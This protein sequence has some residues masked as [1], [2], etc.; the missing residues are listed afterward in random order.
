MRQSSNFELEVIRHGSSS[1]Q[2]Y[3][4]GK[5]YVEGKQGEEFS[6][7]IKNNTSRRVLAVLTVD[8]LSAMDGKTGSFDSSGYILDPWNGITI[9]GWRLNN[10]EVAHFE[11]ARS[12]KSYAASKGKGIHNGVIG[13]AFYYEKQYAP[14]VTISNLPE[15]FPHI[16]PWWEKCPNCPTWPNFEKKYGQSW[17]DNS[18]YNLRASAND[19]G[20]N[21]TFTAQSLGKSGMSMNVVNT[22]AANYSSVGNQQQ[23]MSSSLGTGFGDKTEHR[24]VSVGFERASS[25]P[26]EVLTVYYDTRQG[27]KNR[28]ID[29]EGYTEIASP[30]PGSQ[31]EYN[32][33]CEPPKDWND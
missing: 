21:H 14:N 30:F 12:D 31:N 5:Y 16:H 4:E 25:T 24:V 22:S 7:K 26:T 2:F 8:G 10:K 6:V 27:L 11:F 28:G 33:Y 20:I 9:P 3:Q 29:V 13:C 15:A 19:T 1:K 17:G 32:K 23:V 18:S